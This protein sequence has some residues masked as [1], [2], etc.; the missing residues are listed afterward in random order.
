GEDSSSE[1][2]SLPQST[3]GMKKIATTTL[4]S[5][6]FRPRS[7]VRPSIFALPKHALAELV[8]PTWLEEGNRGRTDVGLVEIG[9][10]VEK[11][12]HGN[13]PPLVLGQNL[14]TDRQG[15]DLRPLYE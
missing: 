3:K 15:S 7:V 8:N 2:D 11:H 5:I 1:R 13:Q 9:H 10:Q 6:P 4:Y 14:G 12:E